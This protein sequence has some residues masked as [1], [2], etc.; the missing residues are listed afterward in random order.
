MSTFLSVVA[1]TTVSAAF[2]MLGVMYAEIKNFR[3]IFNSQYVLGQ[4]NLKALDSLVTKVHHNY[5]Y[6]TLLKDV[7]PNPA[8]ITE[9]EMDILGVVRATFIRDPRIQ[10]EAPADVPSTNPEQS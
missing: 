8:A 4:K 6:R 5:F 9:E 1:F 3:H 7:E 2:F 10:T